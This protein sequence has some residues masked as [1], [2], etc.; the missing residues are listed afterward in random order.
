[1]PLAHFFRRLQ[2]RF[3]RHVPRV[4]QRSLTDC[5]AACLSSI[6]R[7]YGVAKSPL[8]LRHATQT[9]LDGVSLLSIAEAAQSLG[10]E[11]TGVFSSVESLPELPLPAIAQD[12]KSVV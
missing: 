1:M 10:F 5:G 9:T 11:A 3:G 4:R 2:S 6:A 7:Y 8:A 12:R